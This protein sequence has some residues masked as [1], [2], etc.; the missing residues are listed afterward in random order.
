M[1]STAENPPLPR[2]WARRLRSVYRSAGWPLRDGLEVELLAAGL[3]E[4]R[5]D[6]A[7]RETL[8]LTTAGLQLLA[9]SLRRNRAV[10]DAHEQLAQQV[11]RTMQRDGRVVWR[12]LSLR[13]PLPAELGGGW[14]MVRPDVFSVRHTTVETYLVPIAHEVKV[15]RA[16]L[17]ADLKRPAKRSAYLALAAE[18]SY[19]IKAG[20]AEPDELPAECGV[21]LAHPDADGSGWARL[22]GVRAAPRRAMQLPFPVWMALARAVPLEAEEGPQSDLGNPVADP[23]V[24]P[25]QG[26]GPT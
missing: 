18:C 21:I 16:D 2:P 14:A 15:R 26:Q 12:E 11:A 9:A 17:L 23:L 19:V 20:I 24:D 4:A 5:V 3:I 6:A 7:Q 1:T 13:A 10:Y 22:E 25:L 8:H